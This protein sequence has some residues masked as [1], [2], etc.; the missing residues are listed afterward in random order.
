MESAY[1]TNT[2]QSY[3]ANF[4]IFKARCWQEGRSAL[5]ATL[6]SEAESVLAQ[7]KGAAPARAS[8]RRTSIAK[9]HRLLIA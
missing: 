7:S 1:P 9:V 2:I 5:P 4:T 6:E 3:R 8:R